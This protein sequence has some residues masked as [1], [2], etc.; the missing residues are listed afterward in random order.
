[1]IHLRIIQCLGGRIDMELD[2]NLKPINKLAVIV[3][4]FKGVSWETKNSPKGIESAYCFQT[5]P[6]PRNAESLIGI[7]SGRITIIGYFCSQKDNII[8]NKKKSRSDSRWVGRCDCSMYVI[9]RGGSFRKGLKNNKHVDMCSS[10]DAVEY[11]RSKKP[12]IKNNLKFEKYINLM[13]ELISYFCVLNDYLFIP[14]II[15]ILP[16]RKGVNYRG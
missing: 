13:N 6:L 12:K 4:Q 14:F 15:F 16:R 11:M 8:G 1:M 7:K 10:C 2:D 9:R 3:T 5:K